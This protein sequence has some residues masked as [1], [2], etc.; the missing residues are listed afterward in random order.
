MIPYL[1]SSFS[2]RWLKA[3]QG[4]MTVISEGTNATGYIMLRLKQ[5]KIYN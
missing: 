4:Q 2:S 1:A 3:S 5:N